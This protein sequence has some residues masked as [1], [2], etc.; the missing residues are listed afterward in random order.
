MATL[1]GIQ[2]VS[3]VEPAG[4][5]SDFFDPLF[6]IRAERGDVHLGE[7]IF[8][9]A[10]DAGIVLSEVAAVHRTLEDIFQDLTEEQ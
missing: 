5:G 8:T 10:K 7:E 4:D 3:A 9:A 6:R 1:G 2:G